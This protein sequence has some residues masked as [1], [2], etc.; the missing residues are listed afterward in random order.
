M[1]NKKEPPKVFE[2]FYGKK[3]TC[4]VC[5]GKK[6]TIVNEVCLECSTKEEKKDK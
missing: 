4:V 2:N 5:N 3:G 1:N 6:S